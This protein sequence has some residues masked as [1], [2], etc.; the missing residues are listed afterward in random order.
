MGE[1]FLGCYDVWVEV[2]N[3]ECLFVMFG[4]GVFRNFVGRFCR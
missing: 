1:L 3:V 4:V 2:R